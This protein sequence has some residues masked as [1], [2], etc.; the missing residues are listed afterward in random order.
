M[1][2]KA[3]HRAFQDSA[4][5]RFIVLHQ[6]KT[7]P[8]ASFQSLAQARAC[9][10]CAHV[11]KEFVQVEPLAK[12]EQTLSVAGYARYAAIPCASKGRALI[13]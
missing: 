4:Y 6:C 12:L 11:N 3:F 8:S 13:N 10:L 1:E 2:R 9:A 5:K 7:T